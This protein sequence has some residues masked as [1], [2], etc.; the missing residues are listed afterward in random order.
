[1]D[2]FHGIFLKAWCSLRFRVSSSVACFLVCVCVW[3]VFVSALG[4]QLAFCYPPVLLQREN[5]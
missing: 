4:R 2:K 3:G 1:M 5:S